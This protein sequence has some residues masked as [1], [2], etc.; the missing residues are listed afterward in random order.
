[1]WSAVSTDGC[2]A[3]HR[4]ALQVSDLG[5]RKDGHS[6]KTL[7]LARRTGL[8][9]LTLNPLGGSARPFPDRIVGNGASSPSEGTR[10][11]TFVLR[12]S[13]QLKAQDTCVP[14]HQLPTNAGFSVD[15]SALTYR[16]VRIGRKFDYCQ[17]ASGARSFRGERVFGVHDAIAVP[18]FG[19]EPLPVGREVSID[20][21]T[22][23]YG[24]EAR[25]SPLRLRSQQ[26]A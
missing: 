10:L 23:N 13:L 22:S 4:L 19:E 15:R 1:M 5:T 7:I 9:A 21:V 2:Q 14:L 18:L 24:V 20:R 6:A 16:E 11:C 3:A 8:A 12:S 17:T 26:P 25:R